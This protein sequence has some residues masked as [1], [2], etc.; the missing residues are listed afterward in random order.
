MA[1]MAALKEGTAAGTWIVPLRFT[2]TDGTFT[3]ADLI[4]SGVDHSG[5]SYEVRVYLNNE[6][7]RYETP[8]DPGLGYAGR[9]VVFGHGGCYGDVGHCDVPTPSN[10]PTDLRLPHPLTPA[11]KIVT[12][13]DAL[14][15]VLAQDPEGLRSATL[16]AASMAPRQKDRGPTTTL[17]KFDTVEL[18]TYLAG[19]E[20]II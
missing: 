9:F 1:Q 16:V 10:D 6:D 8:R 2:N 18:Q 20:P 11:V 3:R 7:A 17:A 14:R 12:V 19:T 15:R 13:T 5:L 4:F